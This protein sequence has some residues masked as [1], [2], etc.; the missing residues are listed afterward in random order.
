MLRAGK[1]SVWILLICIVGGLGWADG[2]SAEAS[3]DQRLRETM[4]RD[5]DKDCSEDLRHFFDQYMQQIVDRNGESLDAA[6][7]GLLMKHIYQYESASN[8]FY[9]YS[10]IST[11]AGQLNPVTERDVEARDKMIRTA[12]GFSSAT[13]TRMA[14]IPGQ[15]AE[16][17]EIFERSTLNYIELLLM[18]RTVDYGDL[19]ALDVCKKLLNQEYHDYRFRADALRL[20]LQVMCYMAD[21]T[22]AFDPTAF[23]QALRTLPEPK[24]EE[25]KAEVTELVF[26]LQLMQSAMATVGDKRLNSDITDFLQK[27]KLPAEWRYFRGDR[28]SLQHL[29]QER[30]KPRFLRNTPQPAPSVPDLDMW[31]GRVL[32]Y[33]EGKGVFDAKSNELLLAL[34]DVKA[35]GNPISREK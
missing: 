29:V 32:R 14:K 20:R 13:E 16:V 35:P 22:A 3:V 11:V 26:A 5:R 1:Y 6:F 30:G 4:A 17:R 15:A 34:P 2:L 9:Y 24:T 21:R 7:N 18:C 19:E 28:T 33:E 10:R 31:E 12:K 25:D 8:Q 27:N 23:E